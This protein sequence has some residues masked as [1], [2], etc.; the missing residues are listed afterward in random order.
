[1]GTVTGFQDGRSS[2]GLSTPQDCRERIPRSTAAGCTTSSPAARPGCH[3]ALA[4]LAPSIASDSRQNRRFWSALT[5]QRSYT[6]V[7]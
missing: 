7:T 2:G 1:M 5:H 3:A 4:H 6:K